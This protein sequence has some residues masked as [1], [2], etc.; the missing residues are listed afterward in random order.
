MSVNLE[1]LNKQIEVRNDIVHRFGHTKKG[2]EIHMTKGNVVSLI[3][4]TDILVNDISKRI[5]E[6]IEGVAE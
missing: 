4:K 1:I 5:T 3:V 2:D 6:F